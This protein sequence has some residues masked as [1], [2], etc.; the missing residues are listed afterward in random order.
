MRFLLVLTL[1]SAAFFG[2]GL[3]ATYGTWKMNAARSTFGCGSQ[4]K[5]LTVRISG[6]PKARYSPWT[7][8]RPTAGRPV[9]ARFSTWTVSLGG[10]RISDVQ[11][12]NRHG[13]RTSG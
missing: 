6:I 2:Q 1:I 8:P 12:F 9:P 13:G 11:E 10:S 4:F 5:S 3:E 7:A